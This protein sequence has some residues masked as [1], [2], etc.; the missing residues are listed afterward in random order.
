MSARGVQ[1]PLDIQIESDSRQ[2]ARERTKVKKK[3][4]EC[5]PI[6]MSGEEYQVESYG[7]SRHFAAIS[8]QQKLRNVGIQIHKLTVA[9]SG[10]LGN[11][12]CGSKMAWKTKEEEV[13]QR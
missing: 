13:R 10:D 12:S 3:Q 11:A 9:I 6:S 2:Q 5:Y 7:A 1:I 8:D 4:K